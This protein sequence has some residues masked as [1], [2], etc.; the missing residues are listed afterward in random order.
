MRTSAL[1]DRP[2]AGN[3]VETRT[4][5]PG[6][7]PGSRV[8]RNLTVLSGAQVLTWCVAIVWTLFVPRRLGPAG[9]GLIVLYWSAGNVMTVVA[10]MGTRTLLIR[11]IAADHSAGPKLLGAT[12]YLRAL[13]VLPALL[14]MLA[15]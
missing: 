7:A 4:A 12:F 15:Y 8:I 10:A 2:A 5:A 11:E 3:V 1:I 6:V 13:T 9:M 14:L